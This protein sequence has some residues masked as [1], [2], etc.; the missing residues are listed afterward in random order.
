MALVNEYPVSGAPGNIAVTPRPL[1]AGDEIVYNPSRNQTLLL[2]NVGDT[3]SIMVS[4]KSVGG[5]ATLPV[6]GTGDV[7]GLTGGYTFSVPVGMKAVSLKQIQAF[8]KG[9]TTAISVTGDGAN[10]LVAVIY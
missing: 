3:G 7:I 8:L 1:S 5:P 2:S 10:L 4:I 6:P 9:T